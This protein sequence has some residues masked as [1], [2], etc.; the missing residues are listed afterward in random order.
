MQPIT[1]HPNAKVSTKPW[2]AHRWPWLLMLGPFIVLVAGSYTGWLAFSRPDALVVSDYYKQGKAIN[3]DLRRD[4]AAANLGLHF[5]LRYDP[6]LGRLSGNIDSF[7]RPRAGKYLLHLVHSTL[8]EKDILLPVQANEDGVFNIALP[9]LESSRWQVLLENERRD[10][11]L[12]G[13]WSWP[14]QQTIQINADPAPAD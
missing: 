14:Q 5:N 1:M 12:N 9:M 7:N 11:R 3:Q 2:Y 6:A 13:S 10:W 8:P 4:R